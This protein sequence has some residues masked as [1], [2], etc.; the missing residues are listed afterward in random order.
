[1]NILIVA[2]GTPNSRITHRVVALGR[3]LVQRGHDVT[4][5]V[6]SSDRHSGWRLDN[7][8]TMDGIKMVYPFQLR[9]KSFLIN[10]LP[11]ILGASFEVLRRQADVIYL[12]K[13]TPATIPA[14]L[15]KWFKRTPI[16]LDMDDLGSEVMK[17]EGQPS[18][19]WRLVALCERVAANQSKAIVAASRLLEND[20]KASFPAKTVIRLSNAVDPKEFVPVVPPAD[21]IPR[22]IFFGILGRTRI[23]APVLESLP[24]VIAE[25]G[26]SAVQLEILGD[27][28]KRTELEAIASKLNINDSVHFQG[29]TRFEELSQYAA[30]GDI[31][32]CIMPDERTTAACSNQK[33]FQYEALELACIVS[34][35]GDL[36]L[37]VDEGEAGVIVDAADTAGLSKA[38]VALLKD[39]KKRIAMS[40]RGREIATSRYTWSALADQL[41][42]LLETIK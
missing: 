7:P 42:E 22:I 25:L 16:V 18:L 6:P 29:W 35:V 19:I 12:Y 41:E 17:I 34:R 10:L 27:G 36:P 31:A 37:Y 39:D 38:L 14:L 20:Y 28:P 3:E 8:A 30:A 21:R 15:A 33:V 2:T 23:L 4:M 1:M 32:L 9:T 40:K 24:A 13:P 11:Y 26:P 5:I